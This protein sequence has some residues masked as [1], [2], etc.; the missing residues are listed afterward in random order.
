MKAKIIVGLIVLLLLLIWYGVPSNIRYAYEKRFGNPNTIIYSVGL[1][2]MVDNY[3]YGEEYYLYDT[4]NITIDLSGY[5]KKD[6]AMYIFGRYANSND[7]L[8]VILNDRVIYNKKGKRLYEGM[9]YDFR[10]INRHFV[11]KLDGFNFNGT[12]KIV[13][14]T[15]NTSK[16][17][18]VNVNNTGGTT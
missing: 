4:Q 11:I 2:L 8:I 12:N 18:I 7:P 1:G 10:Y 9:F 16:T 3:Q 17:Y 6:I 13:L 5:L 14:S 15:G